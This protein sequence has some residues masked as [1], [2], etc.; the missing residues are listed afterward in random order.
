MGGSFAISHCTS[1]F[2][3]GRPISIKMWAMWVNVGRCSGRCWSIF[4]RRRPRR[5]GTSKERCMSPN[6]KKT[7]IASRK[8]VCGKSCVENR[9]WKIAYSFAKFAKSSSNCAHVHSLL[10]APGMSP[11]RVVSVLYKVVDCF[12]DFSKNR[13]KTHTD[14][15]LRV[16]SICPIDKLR[17]YYMSKKYIKNYRFFLKN[18]FL[19]IV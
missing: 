8:I 4:C 15:L 3:S 11:L 18:I 14:F 6:I 10:V 9:V 7:K 5:L 16:F 1:E 2:G 12:I 13:R 17:Y 19:E